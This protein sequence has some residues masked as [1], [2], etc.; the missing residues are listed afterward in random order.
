MRILLMTTMALLMTVGTAQAASYKKDYCDNQDY[1]TN[2]GSDAGGTYPHLHCAK[3]WITYS[4]SSSQHY[5]FLVGDTLYESKANNAC[6]QADDQDADNL[7]G[8][9]K[10]ICDDFD[11]TC[12]DCN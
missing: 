9:I 5:N 7:K 4:K 12:T 3:T 1:Y 2:D 10:S 6:T 11:D 8:V